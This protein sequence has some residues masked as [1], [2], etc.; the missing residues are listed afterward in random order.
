M[1]PGSHF[2]N[3]EH[4]HILLPRLLGPPDLLPQAVANQKGDAKDGFSGS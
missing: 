4:Q 1:S 3:F 2:G